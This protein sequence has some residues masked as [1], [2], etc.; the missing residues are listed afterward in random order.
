MNIT[1]IANSALSLAP[2]TFED[3]NILGTATT[4]LNLADAANIT[5]GTISTDRLAGSY[6]IDISGIANTAINLADA[7]NI[8]TGIVSTSRLTGSYNIDISGIANTAINLANAAN[9]TTGTINPDRLSGSYNIDISGNS[10]TADLAD[11]VDVSST[12]SSSVYYPTFVSGVGTQ[13]AN[14]N[15]SRF[16][17]IPSTGSFGINT[18]SPNYT[19]DI[20]G[21]VAFNGQ[22]YVSTDPVGL[23]TT[24]GTLSSLSFIGV[25]TDGLLVGDLVVDV[26]QARIFENTKIQSIGSGT[27]TITPDHLV[28]GTEV[29]TLAFSRPFQNGVSA[30]NINQVLGSRGPG[31]PPTW[32][33]P[34]SFISVGVE[35]SNLDLNYNLVFTEQTDGVADLRVD[36]SGIN[37]NPSTETLSVS[38]IV[39]ATSFEGNLVGVASTAIDVIGGIASVTNLEVTGVTT[40]GVVT[41][42]AVTAE[43]IDVETNVNVTN[44]VIA[45]AFIG[46]GVALTGIVTQITG[47]IGVDVTPSTGKGVVK[48]DAYRPTGKTI[49]VNQNG[50]DNNSGLS[51]NNAKRTIKAAASVAVFGDT[52]KVYPGVYVEEN[53]VVLKKTVSVEGTELRNCVVTPR[54]PYLD[55]F[56][57]NNG[58]HITDLSFIGP[59]MTDGA[60]VVALQPLQGVAVDRYFDA[61][62]LIRLNLDYIANETVGFLTSTQYIG[63]GRTQ[64]SDPVLQVVDTQGNPIDSSNCSDDIK[65]IWKCIIH[66]I[67]R[68]GNSKCVGAG[69][70]YYTGDTLV[71]IAGT[72]PN[73]YLI[74]DAT[75]DAIEYSLNVA[76]AIVN[77]ST[78]GG[79]PVGLGTTVTNALYSELTGITTI[80]ANNHGLV[81]DDA[82]KITG[83][84]FTC[85]SGPG[86]VTYPSG[87]YGYIFNVLNVVD[88]N[89]FEVVVGQ[90]TLPHSYV[91]GGTIQKYDNFS[92]NFYQVKDL[93]IQRDPLTGFNN[94]VNGCANVISAMHSCVGI[95]TNIV[96]LGSDAFNIVGIK[97]TYP[98]NSGV[99]F[100]SVIGITSAVYDE[101]SGKTI[102]TA[103]GIN[104][105]EGE[106]IEIRDLAFSCSS[107]GGISTQ[108]F[109]SG[110]YGYDFF[111]DKVND[112]NTIE[113]YVGASTLP[114]TYSGGGIVVDRTVSVTTAVYDNTTGITTIA[115]NG[116]SIETGDLV[117]IRG[118]EFSCPSGSGTTTIYPTGNNGYEFR[119]LNII[120]DVP[121][122]VSTAIYDNNTGIV[123]I[124]APGIDLQ[125]DDLVEIRNLEFS[126]PDS[127]PN[128]LY[129]SGNNGYEFRVL[130][131]IGS[132]F[133]INVGPSTIPHTYVSGGTAVNKSITANDTFTIN[134]GPSTIPHTYVSGGI[135]IPPFSRGVGN[136][137]QGP[138]V[139][140]CTNFVPGS[141]G[142]KIDG[143]AAEPGDQD[144]IGVTGTMSVDSYTQYNQGGIGVSI[145]NGA[146]AQ[147]VSIFTICNDIAIYTESGGQ[148]DITNSNSSFGR[149][150]LYSNGVGDAGTK[151]IYR[152]TAVAI[153]TALEKTNTVTIS[154][155]GSYRPYDG[156]VCYFGELLYFVDTI[157][158]LDGGSGYTAAPRVTI[159]S[160]EG[161]NGITAQASTT[162]EDGKVVSVNIV[163]SGTQYRNPPTIT[164]AP[165]PSGTQATAT[166][167][168]M[169]PIYYT[170]DSATLP[171]AGVSTVSLLQNLNNTV[172][173]GTTVYFSR[174]SL[175]ITSSHSF[176]WV[177]SG[178]DI[179]KAKPALGGVVVPENEVIQAN[180]GRVV[181]TS[182][183]QAGNFKIGDG[184]VIN[185]ATGQISGRDFTKALFTTMTPL[186]LAL[187]E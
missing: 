159:S 101:V 11:T 19:L 68:G 77:N 87:A 95:V 79:Y 3:V 4:A 14:V 106:P 126:C 118:L 5:T 177:G 130:N 52:I 138:Y 18:S 63:A 30:G 176:E 89:T 69:L 109:P 119:V 171:S 186:I 65:D 164:I 83:I 128:L 50:N 6:N 29:R 179:N 121:S 168:R 116:L 160:P 112:D 158:V 36:S 92:H 103:P 149:L 8:T 13:G 163:N 46:D 175:Q 64:E 25:N 122:S 169:Q 165:P 60:A 48:I 35:E 180:G 127:P 157:E 91:S 26:P 152:S 139:R 134:V 133:T 147:L 42:G 28:L 154:G 172:S 73:G 32:L 98:G 41:A 140:N 43:S 114:H 71:H 182:T 174:V 184:V 34:A 167:G 187:S 107:G 132:T 96:G 22:L 76:R 170:V 88:S 137:V 105:V 94:A 78:W 62:R 173:S 44:N 129:P 74:K 155:V 131:S 104:V 150:G 113:V 10:T 31:Q 153:T 40:L 110:R 12:S 135:V 146:Y 80:T 24:S 54:Y 185:Q 82:V 53:P 141:I 55:L 120:R 123:T 86:I 33:D 57:V 102:I 84:G 67:T 144:D 61:A 161:E 16:S 27:I 181:Y 58:C 37:Y 178:N 1:G 166:V 23:G 70:S 51:E 66:D 20:Y 2:G 151:S 115:A 145:S 81:K 15:L 183:D 108:T 143:F 56:H 100:T 49:F 21:D 162:I 90:S 124:T 45:A 148:C 136:I 99:G 111:V 93:G 7:A 142:M 156:Q 47:G 75:I 117:K 9:I 17:L 72:D 85:P 39:S 38:G 125:Y 59:D 97:T